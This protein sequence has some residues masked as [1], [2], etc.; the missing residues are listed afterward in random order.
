RLVDT[1]QRNIVRPV[2]FGRVPVF[3]VDSIDPQLGTGQ[4]IADPSGE[5]PHLLFQKEF[6]TIRYCCSVSRDPLDWRRWSWTADAGPANCGY[7]IAS[8][9]W[10]HSAPGSWRS[11]VPGTYNA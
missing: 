10:T 8:T 4:G 6:E 3:L 1:D 11:A 2:L 9:S 7:R 5:C